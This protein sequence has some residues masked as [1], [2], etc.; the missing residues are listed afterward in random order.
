MSAGDAREAARR[1]VER[2]GVADKAAAKLE[3]LSQGNQQRVQLAAALVQWAAWP[4][5]PRPAL[6]SPSL[7]R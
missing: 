4:W 2:L 6:R 1:W 5:L 7:N 3:T